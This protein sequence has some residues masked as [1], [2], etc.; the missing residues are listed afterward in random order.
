MLDKVI[1]IVE[2]VA[3][4]AFAIFLILLIA[5][6]TNGEPFKYIKWL[7]VLLIVI[8]DAGALWIALKIY[9]K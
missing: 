6:I 7:F 9:N 2:W 1:T 3:A 5:Y 8:I 4:I